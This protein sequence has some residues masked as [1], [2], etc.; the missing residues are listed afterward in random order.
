MGLTECNPDVVRNIRT[1]E[2]EVE[3]LRAQISDTAVEKMEALEVEKDRHR[4]LA[5]SFEER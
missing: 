5:E 4:R 1:L 3:R 2:A